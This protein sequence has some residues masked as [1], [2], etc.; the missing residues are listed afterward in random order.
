MIKFVKPLL[1]QWKLVEYT[2]MKVLNLLPVHQLNKGPPADRMDRT[3]TM[4]L[5]PIINKVLI[6]IIF[7]GNDQ[8]RATAGGTTEDGSTTGQV[9]GITRKE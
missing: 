3:L 8:E 7:Y 5:M 9:E 2:C 6:I 4:N 1:M